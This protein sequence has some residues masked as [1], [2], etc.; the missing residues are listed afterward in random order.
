MFVI[1]DLIT[2]AF[3]HN[4][5]SRQNF[6][7]FHCRHPIHARTVRWRIR[8]VG[9]LCHRPK[10]GCILTNRHKAVRLNWARAHL[11]WNHRQWGSVLFTDESKFNVQNCDGRTRVYCQRGQRFSENCVQK[12]NCGGGGSVHVWAGIT[13]FNKTDLVILNGNVNARRYIDNV[14]HPVALPF[15]RQNYR[16]GNFIYQYDN[17]PAHS[18]RLTVN[19]LATNRI[20]V[21]DWP[22]LS[23]DMSPIEHAWDELARRISARH[24]PPRNVNELTNALINEWNNIPQQVMANLVLSMRRRCPAC[25]AA[26]A[27]TLA[28]TCYFWM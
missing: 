27:V 8:E 9:L 22:S 5:I 28:I 23:P 25:I 3:N 19:F 12:R 15:L 17:A 24:Q 4:P 6:K 7:L 2:I 11:R 1:N 21:L 16:R 18:A 14:L 20:P 10:K 26:M 13:Q